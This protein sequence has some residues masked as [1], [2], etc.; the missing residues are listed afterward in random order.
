MMTKLFALLS[1]DWDSNHLD[2][3]PHIFRNGSTT[4]FYNATLLNSGH[5][6][7]MDIPL[8]IN[9]SLVNESGTINPIKTYEISNTMVLQFFDKSLLNRLHDLLEIRETNPEIEIEL[10]N[11]K[12]IQ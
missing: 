6:S 8:M 2:F 10:I 11:K 3:N 4:D 12:Y 1:S 9:Q 5:A 7:F